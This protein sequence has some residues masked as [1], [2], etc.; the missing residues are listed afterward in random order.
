M[1]IESRTEKIL[2]LAHQIENFQFCSPS[3]DPD[4]QDAVV[5]GFKQLAKRFIGHARKIRNQDL[6][7]SIGEINTDI[8][9]NI[10]EAFDLHSNLLVII[11][12]VR[13]I[14]SQPSVEWAT[15]QEVIDSSD[16]DKM[17]VDEETVT[18][19]HGEVISIEEAIRR[20]DIAPIVRRFGTWAVTTDGVE[21]LITSYSFR[22]DRVREP[23]WVDHMRDKR[24][25]NIHDFVNALTFAQEL[26][27]G[28]SR[29]LKSGQPLK[30][31]LCHAKEDK[32][33]VIE[34]FNKLFVNG[35]QPW[36]DVKNILPGQD[37][38]FEIKKAVRNSDVVIVFLSRKSV[39]KTG[40][41]QKEI[42]IALDAADERPE[43]RIYLIPAKIEDCNVPDRMSDKHWV[44]LYTDEGFD[45]LMQ[46]LY[47]CANS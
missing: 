10:Y 33:A 26:L 12:D 3:A 19:F 9:N 25:V 45:L 17:L 39:D 23:D 4:E 20:F 27:Q 6:Q 43:G 34:I 5:Y 47:S 8:E 29:Y 46:S 16:I 1:S 11:D 30:V 32:P 24:W 18:T 36:M 44:D 21:S 28:R 7:N 41:V 15:L 31:F 40:Y 2:E 14:L 37:W 13:E 38:S 22:F 35:I 42:K